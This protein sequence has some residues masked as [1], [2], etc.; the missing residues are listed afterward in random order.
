MIGALSVVALKGVIGSLFF[1]GT[2]RENRLVIGYSNVLPSYSLVPKEIDSLTSECLE[3]N[4]RLCHD[5]Y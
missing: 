4:Y 2:A 5:Q 3:L 1:G